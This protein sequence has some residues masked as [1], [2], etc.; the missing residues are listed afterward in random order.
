MTTLPP[1]S[2]D[3]AQTLA[4]AVGQAMWARDNATQA[5]GMC[6]SAIGPGS[7]TMT[8]PVRGDMLNGHRICHGGFIF[9]LADSA[10][11][12][13]CNSHNITTVAAG[14]QI[15]FLAPARE[16]EVLVADATERAAMGRT[17]VY[18]ISVRVRDGRQ[19]ALFRGKSHRI[20]GEVIAGLAPP[21]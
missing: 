3:D 17:G 13:A 1:D 18:D 10:F 12:Y 15:D 14:C 7:A 4:E 9:T 5:L 21:A 6:L 16:G 19:I 11:A 20:G 8:M 2:T